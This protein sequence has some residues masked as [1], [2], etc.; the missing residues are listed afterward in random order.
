MESQIA[1]T[2]PRHNH[3]AGLAISLAVLLSGCEAKSD[4]AMAMPPPPEVD[5]AAVL[6]EPVTL[7]ETFTG[8][9]VSPETVELRPRVSGYIIDVAF[10]EGEIVEAGELLFQIDPRPYQARVDAARAD[11]ALAESQLALASSEAGRAKSLLAS[12]AISQ[13][14][15]DQRNA[16]LMSARARVQAARAALDTAELDLQYTQVTA[17]V[18][19]RA[20]RA[21]ITR[22]NLANADQSLLTTVV[23]VDPLYV[24]FEADEKSAVNS[25][26]LLADGG[27]LDVR[28]SLDT[29]VDHPYRGALDFID[30][31]L[32]PGT[33]TLQHRAVVANPGGLIRPGQ[34]ARV[35]MPVVRLSKALLVQR[36][37]VMADQ[38]RRYVYV[39]DDNNRVTPKHV[40]T[41]RQVGDLL[42]IHEGLA[43]GE[44]V[45]INGVQKV[46]GAGIEVR[47]QLIAMKDTDHNGNAVATA[48][49]LAE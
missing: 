22:G 37:A 32:N 21:L 13:E 39:V 41:G 29:G 20:G 6:E 16:A 19:G 23:S 36:K 35:E 27:L 46:F 25:Q 24:Y 3:L 18:G 11:L 47:P 14:E 28:I 49:E 44:L 40:T 5:V 7:W 8:R 1:R 10:E 2:N 15:Y 17:P 33:G 48:Q 43:P 9:V 30:N 38:D 34:F 12:R 31:H 4:A 26:E 45:I 42:V